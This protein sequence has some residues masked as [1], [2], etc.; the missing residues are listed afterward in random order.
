MNTLVQDVRVAVRSLPKDWSFTIVVVLCL[1]LGTGATTAMFSIVDAVLLRPLP[2][3]EP[4]HLVRLYDQLTI[5]NRTWIGAVPSA[6]YLDWR[7]QSTLFEQLVAYDPTSMNLAND[8][9][10]QRLTAVHATANLFAAL[11]VK[12]VLGRGFLPSD[13]Q[14][15]APLVAVL[16]YALWRGR[17]GGD[18]AILGR[19]ITL[20][21]AP[22]TVI[23][24]M[25][26]AFTFPVTRAT[27]VWVPRRFTPA[28]EA[29]SSN[30][31]LQVAGRLKPAATIVAARAQMNQ[32]AARLTQEY[33]GGRASHT[34]RLL[35]LYES[36]FGR[37]R[38]GLFVL[39]GASA[40]V[41]V[42]A[43]VNVA[44][45]FLS[46]TAARRREVAVRYALGARRGHL[47]RQFL[48]EGIVLSLV[49]ALAG[50]GVAHF[51]VRA[52][53]ALAFE[54][55]PRARSVTFDPGVFTFLLVVAVTTGVGFAL[56]PALQGSSV[57]L[58]DG[59]SEGGRHGSGSRS[60]QRFRNVL[61]LVE[62][63][64]ALV[65]TVGAALL[66][67]AFVRL[68]A[69]PYG[70]TT[71][72]VLTLHVSIA[73]QKYKSRLS[74]R[75]YRPVLER[76]AALPGVAAAGWVSL[77]PLQEY[78]SNGN[79]TIAGRPPA[80]RGQEPF[81]EFRWASAGYF[82]ALRIPIREG[83]NF[84][85]R[86]EAG[87][88]PVV[89]INAALAHKYFPQENPIGQRLVLDT[90]VLTIVGVIG[91]VRGAG[92]D[93][94]PM[95]EMYFSY[96]QASEYVPNTMTLVIR[97][98]VPPTSL[99]P[100]ISGAV[101]SVDPAQPIYDVE[102]MDQVVSESLVNRRLYLRLLGAFAG[103]ALVLAAAGIYG[104]TSYLVTQRTREIGIRVAIG[105]GAASVV[106]QV[107][108]QGAKVAAL[109][110]LVGLVSAYGLTRL[111]ASLLYGV[112]ATDPAVFGGVAALLMGVA[113]VA[114]YIPA[115]RA[116]RVDPTIALRSE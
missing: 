108:C 59:L 89:I 26:R 97:A 85:D 38:P 109:G 66:L 95:P 101:R 90:L 80:L 31:F 28:E 88:P 5:D 111:L 21:D 84:S 115:R 70:L 86:D 50:L 72:H 73:A 82:A 61:V 11:R 78:W 99:T 98:T 9:P 76:V 114:C 65:L 23:G 45:L 64:L 41:L 33:P 63:A 49:G 54:E 68:E 27:D 60:Q 62:I 100:A 47:V 15:N 51:G 48:T 67:K 116:T 104:V 56:V 39:L 25:P 7:R 3:P 22:Y 17:F 52:L 71:D 35:S 81:S 4:E 74:D 14:L 2:Y 24:V 94:K 42:V 34:V 18:R 36:L 10:P 8:G 87:A 106:R 102:T 77:L 57:D 1:A 83:R 6:I 93:Q 53:T 46:R 44:N 92:L 112:S 96:R 20:D 91:D 19:T 110:T 58:R 113:L 13:G 12:P 30:Q 43:C 79:F 37:A 29:R 40:L 32:I 107:V 103:M 75:F 105:A 55:I 69:T 16:S